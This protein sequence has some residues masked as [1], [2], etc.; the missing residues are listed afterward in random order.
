MLDSHGNR[1]AAHAVN[2]TT[3]ASLLLLEWGTK[4]H[5]Q[6]KIPSIVGAAIASTVSYTTHAC[7]AIVM[8]KTDQHQQLYGENWHMLY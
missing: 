1:A 4:Q 3:H 8:Q 6:L 5:L 7:M 2:Y